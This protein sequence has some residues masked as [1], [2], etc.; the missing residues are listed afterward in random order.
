MTA[1]YENIATTTLG[2]AASTIEFTNISQSYTDLIAVVQLAS[3]SD[4]NIFIRVGDGSLNTGSLYS[5]T[6]LNGNGSSAVSDRQ[7]NQS[8]ITLTRSGYPDATIGNSMTIIQFMNYSNTTT[9]KTWLVRSNRASTGVDA[10]VGLIRSTS[11]INIISFATTGFG[12]SNS[13]LANS[14]I[15]LYGIKAE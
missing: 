6:R 11:K 14:T 7:S 12:T 9:N 8:F 10:L 15:T 5:T 4:D 3:S 2:S 1:T 13:I